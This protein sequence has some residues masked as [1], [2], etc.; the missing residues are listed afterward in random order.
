ML[1]SPESSDLFR[2]RRI[3]QKEI[4]RRLG[5]SQ[6]AVSVALSG[7]GAGVGLSDETADLIRREAGYSRLLT[8]ATDRDLLALG[9][10]RVDGIAFA[11][12]IPSRK[13]PSQFIPPKCGLFEL[14]LR[15]SSSNRP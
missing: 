2:M 11:G 6:A 13:T 4:A 12:V 5:V 8:G 1:W 10:H 7:K 9:R 14:R 3:T 15:P